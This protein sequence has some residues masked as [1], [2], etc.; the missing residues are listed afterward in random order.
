M[1]RLNS[2][3][4]LTINGLV[5]LV[6]IASW[7]SNRSE[8]FP[9]SNHHTHFYSS[10]WSKD[11][12]VTMVRN[13]A[14]RNTYIKNNIRSGLGKFLIYR[15]LLM[16]ATNNNILFLLVQEGTGDTV[17]PF[18]LV[19]HL[20]DNPKCPNKYKNIRVHWRKYMNEVM[21][22]GGKVIK[23]HH[24]ELQKFMLKYTYVP[25]KKEIDILRVE[26]L[27]SVSRKPLDNR[28]AYAKEVLGEHAYLED[29]R[30]KFVSMKNIKQDQDW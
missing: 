28:M 19:S 11:L 6:Y 14:T 26:I 10:N 27:S 7:N 8:T 13:I 18:W 2:A 5:P 23:I 3:T 9:T 30:V 16:D 29:N 20:F 1:S 4:L 12:R 21:D 22:D 25:T 24:D 17:K 15:G